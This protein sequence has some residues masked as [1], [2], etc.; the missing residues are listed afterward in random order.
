MDL[1]YGTKQVAATPMT[2]AA[3]ADYRGW[4]LPADENGDDPG[5]L[6]EYRDGGK[7]NHKDH[8]G[9]ISW[10]PAAQFD[11]A[12]QPVA[13]GLSFGHALAAL[14]AGH[15]VARAGW[16]G[17]GMYIWLEKGSFYGPAFGFEG[18]DA[19]VAPDHR[20]T[21]GGVR[22]GLFEISNTT[23]AVRMPYLCMMAADGVKVTGWLASQTDMLADDWRVVAD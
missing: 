16:N 17:K 15:R 11:A 9:Y 18:A 13:G 2:R 12:Y 7:P 6:V 22:L 20:S 5:Y 19:E 3:Y 21:Q 10:S 1:F 23:G 8:E 14:K 4:T